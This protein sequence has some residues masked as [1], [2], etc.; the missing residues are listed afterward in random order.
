MENRTKPFCVYKRK[1]IPELYATHV[2]ASESKVVMVE[3]FSA[4]QLNGKYNKN[5]YSF[6]VDP[7]K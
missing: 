4:L 7:R 2:C 1:Q 6:Q 5:L 3:C